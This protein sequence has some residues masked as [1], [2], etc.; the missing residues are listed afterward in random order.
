MAGLSEAWNM[1]YNHRRYLYPNLNGFL[2]EGYRGC[3][4]TIFGHLSQFLNNLCNYNHLEAQIFAS[5]S[6]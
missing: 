3:L 1:D 4:D 6:T 2:T 5:L